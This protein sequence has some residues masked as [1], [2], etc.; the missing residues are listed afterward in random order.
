MN[1]VTLYLCILMF[2]IGSNYAL[3]E[4]LMSIYLHEELK[5]RPVEIVI[6]YSCLYAGAI[7]FSLAIPY[8]G[9]VK[10]KRKQLILLTSVLGLTAYVILYH[11]KHPYILIGCS[12]FFLAPA[13]S[14]TSQIFAYIRQLD[15]NSK[16]V[17]MFR[18][19]FAAAWVVG[20]AVGA[21]IANIYGFSSLFA[22]LMLS[23]VLVVLFISGVPDVEIPERQEDNADVAA[24]NKSRVLLIFLAF[25]MLQGTNSLSAIY[26]S[27]IVVEELSLDLRFAGYIFAACASLEV[28]YFFLLSKASTSGSE[29]KLLI[30]GSLCAVLYYTILSSSSSYILVLMSQLLNAAFIA[31]MTGVGMAWMQSMIPNRPGLSTGIF[32]NSSRV[33]ILMLLPISSAYSGSSMGKFSDGIVVAIYAALFALLLFVYIHLTENGSSKRRKF[34]GSDTAV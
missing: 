4:P 9:D 15:G 5:F 1:K 25:A 20:P 7:T 26:T 32:M 6:F 18:G 33:G 16:R 13:A 27:I 14:N 22:M 10:F 29:T 3:L 12:A 31:V 2:L 23:G 30:A 11:F 8:L 34:V 19:I 24:V 17:V 21:T 28:V